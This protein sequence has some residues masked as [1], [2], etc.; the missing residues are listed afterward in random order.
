MR[1]TFISPCL[2]TYGGDRVIGRYASGLAARGHDVRVVSVGEPKSTL[3]YE[4]LNTIT[5]GHDA[6]PRSKA[7]YVRAGWSL[8]RRVK[9]P[10][11]I[12]PTWTPT[13]PL[14]VL[15]K[16]VRAGRRTVWLAQD[17]AEMFANLPTE[18]WLLE[19]GAR[20]CD[21]VITI[22]T[23]CA[24]HLHAE[25]HPG[26]VTI[27]HSGV[28][29]VFF[30]D[31]VPK[32]RS[33][34]LLFVG[35]P[36]PRKGWREF[37]TAWEGLRSTRPNLAFVIVCRRP[38]KDE[39]PEGGTCLVGLSDEEVAE[40]YRRAA[41][42]VCASHAEGWGLPA[43]EAMASGTPV[44]TTLHGGCEA[45]ARDGLNCLTAPVADSPALQRGIARI[46]SDRALC[47]RLIR[48]GRDTAGQYSWPSAIDRF[49]AV[50]SG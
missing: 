31:G 6:F 17:Y 14:A 21:A 12:I 26:K 39:L 41:V 46:L 35:D 33:E 8:V 47:E 20:Y 37:V 48:A 13:L 15:L 34:V 28:D 10:G 25:R 16:A 42:Y 27:I 11:V 40:Q 30:F 32:K 22:S 49:E 7:D 38:P 2:D 5:L 36:I 29:E 9:D 45:Y 23:L 50:C 3:F 43:L 19:A 44:V 18:V 24:E 4:G 1:A